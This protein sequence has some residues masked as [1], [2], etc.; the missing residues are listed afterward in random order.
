MILIFVFILK[1]KIFPKGWTL[2]PNLFIIV[3][4]IAIILTYSRG[5]YLM[6]LVSVATYSIITK[7]WKILASLVTSFVII[8]LLLTPRFNF[9][10]T[11]L[12]R[13]TSIGTRINSM[14]ESIYI[15]EQKPFGV[16]FNTYRYARTKYGYSDNYGTSISHAGAG[17]DNSFLFVLVTTGFVGLVLYL[18]LIYKIFRLGIENMQKNKYAL[19]LVVSLAGLVVNALTIN[20]L[21]YS[22]IMIWI[23]VLTGL[24]ESSLRE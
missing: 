3:N 22:Y 18:N 6:L 12:L 10:S 11:N 1:D 2:I 4:F 19:V 9:E 20:S 17:V 7:K 24:T 16:G 8:F 13:V 21:F 23:F 5:A 15:F 14:Q